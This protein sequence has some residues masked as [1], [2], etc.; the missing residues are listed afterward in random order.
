MSDT[1]QV[2]ER[3]GIKIHIFKMSQQKEINEC[4]RTIRLAEHGVHMN[5]GSMFKEG[6]ICIFENLEPIEDTSSKVAL[7]HTSE[8]ML[9][10]I[11]QKWRKFQTALQETDITL[12]YYKPRMKSESSMIRTEATKIVRDHEK[13]RADILSRMAMCRR[14]ALLVVSGRYP[15]LELDK[16]ESETYKSAFEL[17]P[18]EQVEPDSVYGK[19]PQEDPKG[20]QGS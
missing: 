2:P 14:E 7:G 4:L 11:D 15:Q 20:R 8:E 19:P 5:P 18:L 17:P 9:R 1:Y 12:E 3:K 10:S 6:N 13:L 16:E